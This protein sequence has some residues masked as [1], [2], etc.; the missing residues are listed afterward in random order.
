MSF[1]ERAD[2]LDTT[3]TNIKGIL[4]VSLNTEITRWTFQVMCLKC[5]RQLERTHPSRARDFKGKNYEREYFRKYFEALNWLHKEG[6][7][8]ITNS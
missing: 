7:S 1:F 8:P 6:F 3:K 2:I 4:C 5:L